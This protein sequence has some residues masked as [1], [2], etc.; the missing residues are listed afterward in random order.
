MSA[1]QTPV[2]ILC[3]WAWSK[4]NLKNTQAAAK[5]NPNSEN[6]RE[7]QPAIVA[8]RHALRK[9]KQLDEAYSWHH[10][11]LEMFK[12]ATLEQGELL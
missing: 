12:P 10:E 1:E 7:V 9:K 11:L 8:Y 5:A 2:E 3:E 4:V 6:N